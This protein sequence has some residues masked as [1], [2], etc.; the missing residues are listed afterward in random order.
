[1]KLT[2]PSGGTVETTEDLAAPYFRQGWSAKP[3]KNAARASA[4]SGD[5]APVTKKENNDGD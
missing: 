4:K 1:M 3:T 5:A 2:H